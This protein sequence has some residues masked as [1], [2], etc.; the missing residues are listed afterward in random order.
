MP[1]GNSSDKLDMRLG[2]FF[3][4]WATY[5]LPELPGLRPGPDVLN[6]CARKAFPYYIFSSFL[7]L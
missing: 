7:I 6:R 5:K 1:P 3:N 4:L 2:L